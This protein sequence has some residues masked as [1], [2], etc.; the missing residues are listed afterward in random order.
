MK[1]ENLTILVRSG[2]RSGK[3]TELR[4]MAETARKEGY[5]VEEVQPNRNPK[6]D[7]LP[8][9]TIHSVDFKRPR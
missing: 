4:E 7:P 5:I 1:D 9:P 2:V 3:T 6:K 8:M